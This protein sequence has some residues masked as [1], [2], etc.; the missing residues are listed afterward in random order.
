MENATQENLQQETAAQE[1]AQVSVKEIVTLRLGETEEITLIEANLPFRNGR[2]A[3]DKKTYSQYRY[4]GVVFTV[5]DGNDFLEAVRASDLQWVKLLRKEEMKDGKPITRYEFDSHKAQSSY[6][7]R[8][9]RE[10]EHEANLNAIRG[11][12]ATAI[13]AAPTNRQQLEA[14]A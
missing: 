9:R 7:A 11:K 10:A 4:N 3:Q 6:F 5:P 8:E 2:R 1:T 14:S 13:T 12:S